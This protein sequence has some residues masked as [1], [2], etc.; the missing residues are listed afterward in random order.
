MGAR[1]VGSVIKMESRIEFKNI[2]Y[3]IDS[4]IVYSQILKENIKVGTFVANRI[5]EIREKTHTDDWY[6]I[7]TDL[8]VADMLTRPNCDYDIGIS[9]VWQNG[10][11]F[12]RN[13]LNEWPIK[14][15]R[16]SSGDEVVL[17]TTKETTEPLSNV[18]DISRF[19]SYAKL[20]RV[21][22][23]LWNVVKGRSFKSIFRIPISSELKDAEKYWVIQ[24][25]STLQ[26]DWEKRF[27]KLGPFKDQNGIIYVGSRVM[28]WMKDNWN[29]EAF[30]LLPKDHKFTQLCV[31]DMHNKDHAG[32]EASICKL[33]TRFWIPQVRKLMKSIKANCITCRRLEKKLVGQRMGPIINERLKPCPPFYHSALDLFGP[34]LIKDTV[35]GRCRKKVYGV[36]INCLT[37]RASYV[38]LVEGY[39]ADS[40]LTTLRRFVSLRGYPS[41]MYSDSGTQLVLAKKEL[42]EEVKIWEQDKIL[43]FG[44]MEG[45]KWTTTKSADAP[46]ENGCSEAIIGLVKRALV[47][48]IGDSVLTFSELQTVLFEVSNL[49]NERPIGIKPGTNIDLGT[50][51]CPN[52]LILG[53]CSVMV[54][55]GA[56]NFSAKFKL[57][58][59][60]INDITKA[61]WKRW[62]RDYFHTLIVCQK[63]HHDKRNV[64]I[65]DIV[66]VQDSNAIRGFWRMAQVSEV[67]PST[68]GKVRDVEL[69]Y[70]LQK[71]SSL[72][73]GQPDSKIKRSVHRLVLLLP[74]EEQE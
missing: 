20:I 31:I 66:L 45:M 9:S 74:I 2:Y 69:R 56:F 53:R 14:R 65:G 5:K 48:V 39:D 16:G 13:S 50:Y 57:R 72:Y 22:A 12:L 4:E 43:N 61:F 46:W 35:K 51:L 73:R 49:L 30:I 40:F 11:A 19:G 18:I 21:A 36:I 25:Q 27:V 59:N 47:R 3:L 24:A 44:Q 54:P 58:Q 67:I 37:T 62:M 7:P 42:N 32:I 38:D 28:H 6:W 64:K 60:F 10:P 23:R 71:N 17:V 63:W 55:E 26:P 68:D 41:T 29:C 33:Q 1:L 34:F 70:K 8:N 15:N 52:D